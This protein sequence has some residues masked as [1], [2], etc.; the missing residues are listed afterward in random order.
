MTVD[1]SAP[2]L[3]VMAAGGGSRYGG[4]K[5]LAPIGP[6]GESIMEYSLHDATAAGFGRVV[7]VIRPEHE[8]QFEDKF[9]R[10]AR[11]R[12]DIAYA[13]QQLE[14]HVPERYR[15][16]NRHKPWGT[17]HALLSAREQVPGAF[18][19]INADDYYGPTAFTTICQFLKQP[20]ASH[21]MQGGM[22]GYQIRN[23]LSDHGSVSR[24]VCERDASG[25]L[26]SI[27]ERYKI[28]RD[29]DGARFVDEQ[30]VE[31]FA[32]GNQIVSM[33]LW[34]FPQAM[35]DRLESHFAEFL[36]ENPPADREFE[37]PSNLMRLVRSGDLEITVLETSE[38]WCGLT[39]QD[40]LPTV[41]ARINALVAAGN[42]P[43]QLW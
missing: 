7:L 43:E 34:G 30:G 32:P 4:L 35:L 6:Y 12:I 22:V 16:V 36:A 24:G 29:G 23:T 1:N 20:H 14:G 38:Q 42:Y 27:V 11:G 8:E 25:H 33:N 41:L 3:V 21:P 40:D 2:T 19:A 28:V 17:A 5:Q 10:A 15:P 37:I 26:T 13:Y 39:Y 31:Q 18:A 9:V